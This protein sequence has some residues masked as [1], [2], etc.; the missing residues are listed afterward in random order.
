MSIEQQM[1]IIGITLGWIIVIGYS[2]AGMNYLVKFVNRK[3]IVRLPK[4]SLFRIRYTRFMR[5]V[6]RSHVYVP[7]FLITV[8]LLHLSMEL[9]HAGFFI[10]GVIVFVLMF[11]EIVLG[12]YGAYFKNRKKGTW[13]YV[14][15][16]VAIL[17]FLAINMHVI[18]A[19][20][21]HP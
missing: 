18:V 5:A 2:W 8:M 7:L 21:L 10:T 11:L 15:R 19:I 20:I 6:I 13:L 4:D 3:W 14:H 9:I 1:H 12:A 16:T 17:L